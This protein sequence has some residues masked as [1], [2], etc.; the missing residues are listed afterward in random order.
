MDLLRGLAVAAVDAS[1]L[2]VAAIWS[3]PESCALLDRYW[4]GV[5]VN[6]VDVVSLAE[7]TTSSRSSPSSR[8]A[9]TY[10]TPRRMV[11]VDPDGRVVR[12]LVEDA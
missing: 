10:L 2:L 5:V 4:F 3:L 8:L 6:M 9:K 7:T 11:A 1:M 12:L